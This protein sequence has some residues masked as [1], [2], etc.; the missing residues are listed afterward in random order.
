MGARLVQQRTF[1]YTGKEIVHGL[2][3]HGEIIIGTVPFADGFVA[4]MIDGNGSNGG[5]N[6]D[7]EQRGKSG[8]DPRPVP[9]RPS[10]Q[11]YR[12]GIG[13]GRHGL[14][15]QPALDVLGQVSR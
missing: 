1:A 4:P 15:T 10:C 9:T 11:F 6:R 3:C 5:D 7:G 2:S 12:K 14:V 13:K 8:L